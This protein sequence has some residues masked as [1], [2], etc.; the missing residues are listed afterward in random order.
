MSANHL[1]LVA[2]LAASVFLLLDARSRALAV[3]AAVVSGIALAV[4]AGV[5]SIHVQH[6]SLGLSAGLLVLGILLVLRVAEKMRVVAS[7]VIAV[8]GATGVLGA[9]F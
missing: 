5:M 9:L 3:G 7:T 4:A 8:V 6:L 2:A 1:G